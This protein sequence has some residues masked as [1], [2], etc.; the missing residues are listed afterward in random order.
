MSANVHP[1]AVVDP[2]AWLG[3]GVMVGPYAVIEADTVIGDGCSIAAHAVIKR[4]TRLGSNNRIF[5]H[6]VI[7]GDP[8]DYK[9]S[10]GVS[11]VEVGDGNCIREF[12]T[13]HRSNHEGGSTN[14]GNDCF[15]M[16]GCHIAHDCLLGDHIIIANGALLGGHVEIADRACISG[17]VTIHQFCRVGRYAMVAASARVNQD[18]LPFVITDG[19]PAR[20]RA[21]NLVG[22]KRA[23]FS[24]EDIRAVRRAYGCLRTAPTL[25]EALTRMNVLGSAL[26]DEMALFIRSSARGFAHCR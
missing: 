1:T 7:G 13:I 15:L 20:A 10:G 2:S 14:V 19:H 17:A 26:A 22:L 23:G 8:Q 4:H 9:F 25:E 5:E 16:A 11:R 3:C 6:A 18:C 24:A 12:V 21:L